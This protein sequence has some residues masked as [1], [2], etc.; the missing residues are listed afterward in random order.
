M[1]APSRPHSRNGCSR[2]SEPRR[3][4][5]HQAKLFVRDIVQ[6]TPPGGFE[7]RR[8]GDTHWRPGQTAR[9]SS[10]AK[11]RRRGRNAILADL[12]KIMAPAKQSKLSDARSI[13]QRFR[14][15]RGRVGGDFTRGRDR[16]FRVQKAALKAEIQRSVGN[17]GVLAAGW[18]AAARKLGLKLPGSPAMAPHTAPSA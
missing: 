9:L 4:P 18:A 12:A 8:E 13:H 5:R 14:N 3:P 6:I 1:T 10:L 2:A 15:N 16:R 11:S 17:V 7:L